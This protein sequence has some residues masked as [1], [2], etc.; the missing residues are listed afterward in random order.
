MGYNINF[1]SS[2]KKIA[3]IRLSVL[4]LLM[5]GVTLSL[6]TIVEQDQSLEFYK[7]K[8]TSQN[9]LFGCIDWRF[10]FL[11]GLNHLYTT[12]GFIPFIVFFCLSLML[13]TLSIQ[14]PVLTR[15]RNWKFNN[16]TKDTKKDNFFLISN[17]SSVFLF[18]LY[19]LN[20]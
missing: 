8:Y 6:G 10:V 1:Y 13:C 5:I 9:L 20:Y 14:I 15:L 3:S 7:Q 4:L 12:P 18:Q 11:L 19:S 2:L 17:L 16:F